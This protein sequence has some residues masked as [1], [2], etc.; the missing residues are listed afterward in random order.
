MKRL[1]V[2]ALAV[3]GIMSSGCIVRFGTLYETGAGDNET[4]HFVGLATNL[5]T[6]DVVGASVQVDFFDSSNRLLDTEFVSPCTRTLQVGKSAPIEADLPTGLTAHHVQ[7]TVRPLTIGKKTVADLDVNNIQITEEG[8]N[9]HITGDIDVGNKD[10]FGVTVCAALLDGDGTVLKVGRDITSPANIDSDDSGTFDV[11]MLTDDDAEQFQLWVDAVVHNPN[12][13][14]APVVVGPEDF[15]AA[16]QNTGALSPADSVDGGDWV[17]PDNG[18]AED[19]AE[20]T[21]EIVNGAEK[22]EVY[23]DYPLD[24]ADIPNDATITGIAV[25]PEWFVNEVG[26]DAKITIALSWDGGAHW[27][28]AKTDSAES[29]DEE[30]TATLGGS[31]DDWGRDWDVDELTDADFQVRITADTDGTSTRT[32][33]LDWIPVTVYFTED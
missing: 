13:V 15:S 6:I 10:L 33:S 31:D 30:H 11:S 19:E 21:I 25:S 14:T 12:D 16:V 9:T 28:S 27:T 8:D 32:F 1:L 29:I 22:S 23:S 7:P 26:G 5:S 18:F 20:A 3:I 24:A 17:T 2:L 4:S